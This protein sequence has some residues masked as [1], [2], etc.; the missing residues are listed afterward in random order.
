MKVKRK[1]TVLLILSLLISNVVGAVSITDEIDSNQEIILDNIKENETDN[2][3]IDNVED[4]NNINDIDNKLSTEII[5]DKFYNNSEK[6]IEN[7]NRVAQDVSHKVK[8]S[9]IDVNVDYGNG[10][11]AFILDGVLKEGGQNPKVGN[12]IMF[13][14]KWS[15]DSDNLKDIQLGDLIYFNLPNDYFRFDDTSKE[16]EI[17]DAYGEVLG[18]LKINNNRIVLELNQNALTK[19]SLEGGFVFAYGRI[20]SA[21]ENIEIETGGIQLPPITIESPGVSDPDGE[22]EFSALIHKYGEQYDNSDKMYWRILLNYENAMKRFNGENPDTLNNTF[23]I[24]ELEEGQ[25]LDNFSINGLYNYATKNGKMAAQTFGSVNLGSLNNPGQFKKMEAYPSETK[26]DFMNRLKS[27][28]VPAFGV[29]DNK[30]IVIYLGDIPGEN[31]KL[32]N[33]I[34]LKDELLRRAQAGD[35]SV[36]MYYKTLEHYQR[37]IEDNLILFDIIINTIADNDSETKV[38]NN[39][40]KLIYGDKEVSTNES[41]IKFQ[42]LGGG[43]KAVEKGSI[44]IVK[45]DDN[46]KALENIGFRLDIWN[47]EKQEFEENKEFSGFTDEKGKLIFKG[48]SSR[49]YKII[50]FQGLE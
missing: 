47:E 6:E 3:I 1:I 41:E 45:K 36:E 26:E 22:N 8:I 24:D 44:E 28:N 2:E 17:T 16:Q 35:I 21:G 10:F 18:K 11:E 32:P 12:K 30:I 43:A 27:E 5:N 20:N 49:K 33:H 13:N 19:D 25:T 7:F 9:G 48:L 23:L 4:E 46:N 29:I 38:F 34:E 50:E 39:T 42:A 15:I 14:Y 40:A 37:G 31:F